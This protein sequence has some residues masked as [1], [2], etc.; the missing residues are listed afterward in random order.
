MTTK[1]EKYKSDKTRNARTSSLLRTCCSHSRLFCRLR[2]CLLLRQRRLLFNHLRSSALS[3]FSTGFC[4][5]R[6]FH[7]L[8]SSIFHI[9]LSPFFF[10]NSR[11]F[12][13]Y[14]S[15]LLPDDASGR[16]VVN[17]TACWST[18][19]CSLNYYTIET[20]YKQMSKYFYSRSYSMLLPPWFTTLRIDIFCR[21][22]KYSNVKL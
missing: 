11:A 3:P 19:C 10:I 6:I 12:S 13:Y 4:H 18:V 22:E 1:C 14:L 20:T 2:C 16:N 7:T 9:S 8:L 15:F 5:F 17:S 21:R